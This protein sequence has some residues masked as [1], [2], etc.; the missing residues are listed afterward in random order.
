MLEQKLQEEVLRFKEI[1][2]YA[3]NLMLEQDAP[4]PPP[5]AGGDLGA[6]VPPPP[7]G[8]DLGA[9]APPPPPP[10]GDMGVGGSDTT[11][12]IDITDLVNM[13]K[14]IKKEIDDNKQDNTSVISKMDDV[15]TKLNDLEQK[16]AQ[17]DSVMSKIDDLGNKVQQMKPP[18]PEE[19]LEMRS[20]DSYPFNQNPQQFFAQKGQ[21]MRASGK[22]EYVLTKQDIQDYST[23]Q[24]RTSFN[25]EENEFKF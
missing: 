10:T 17:M 9:G 20:L 18:T 22:N 2:K 15:F 19:R 24:M 6:G 12:E 7:A 5:P 11:E 1:N 21:E 8:G 14:N 4:P 25:P 16:L 13:T 23:E 3:K